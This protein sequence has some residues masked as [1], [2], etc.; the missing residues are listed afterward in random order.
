[1]PQ[2]CPDTALFAGQLS[3]IDYGVQGS[4][5]MYCLCGEPKLADLLDDPILHL[6]MA[7]D[8]ISQD[9]LCRVLDD[10]RRRRQSAGEDG[11][12]F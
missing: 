9:D 5:G 6:L 12:R 10:A 1:M 2:S 8:R 11:W 7:R 3:L 4:W